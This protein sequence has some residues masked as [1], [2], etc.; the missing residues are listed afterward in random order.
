MCQTA[1]AAAPP[2]T[3]LWSWFAEDDFRPLAQP[4]VGVAYLALSLR[5]DGVEKVIP[6]PRLVPVRIPPETYRMAVIRFDN[7]VD[8]PHRA[9]FSATQREQAVNMVAEI[10]ALAHPQAI[11]IDFDAPLSARP[12]YRQ[13]LTDLRER[14]GP[15]IFISITSLV[16]WCDSEASWLSALPVNEIVPMAFDM[17][18]STPAT[19]TM[20]QKGGKFPFGGCRDSI[21]LMIAGNGAPEIKPHQGQRAYLF[22]GYT[23]WS[24][25][26]IASAI[27]LFQ[28]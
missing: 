25:D 28:P 11:Q 13:L 14:L 22:T 24:A 26:L 2:K 12:F 27:K 23:K 19:V 8:G 18:Q 5:F 4:G 9:S 10:A 17:G 3:M 16:S 20:L 1:F 15:D 7:E 21:G 6:S